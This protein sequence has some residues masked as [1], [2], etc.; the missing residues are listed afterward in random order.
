VSFGIWFLTFSRSHC[1]HL[2][3]KKSKRISL[4]LLDPTEEGSTIIRNMGNHLPNNLSV[5][6][7]KTLA[8]GS[9]ALRISSVTLLFP[10]IGHV[11]YITWKAAKQMLLL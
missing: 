2:W 7:Q 10:V 6:S 1:F 3:V 9:T 4:G 5:I 8:F 11:L